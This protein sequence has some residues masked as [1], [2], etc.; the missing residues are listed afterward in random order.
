[1]T[2]TSRHTRTARIVRPDETAVACVIRAISRVGA[3]LEL[4]PGEALTPSFTLAC[5]R[6]AFEARRV[7]RKGD[8]VGVML[9]RAVAA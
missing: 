9:R 5:G 2:A 4:P 6:E 8:V 7:W 3:T 1:M